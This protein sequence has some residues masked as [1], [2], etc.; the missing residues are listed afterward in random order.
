[1]CYMLF[2]NSYNG[3]VL[4]KTDGDISIVYF[5]ERIMYMHTLY[6]LFYIRQYRVTIL[7]CLVVFSSS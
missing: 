1:M 7:L 3:D 4:T 5:S 2:I 6:Y